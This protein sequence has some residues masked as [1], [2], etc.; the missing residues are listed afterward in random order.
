MMCSH[1]DDMLRNVRANNYMPNSTALTS[2]RIL[3]ENPTQKKQMY[4]LYQLTLTPNC[5]YTAVILQY[6]HT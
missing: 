6:Y 4:T 2:N 1:A 3:S 5:F